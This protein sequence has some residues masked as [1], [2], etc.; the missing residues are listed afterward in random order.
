M[1]RAAPTL[2]LDTCAMI[3]I[4]NASRIDDVADR[5]IGK[6]AADNRLFISPMSA[7][8]MGIGVA[9]GRLM[10]P[11]GPLEFF[12]RFVAQIGARPSPLTPEILVGSSMLPGSPHNDPMDRIL[13]ATARM[14]DMILV[15]RDRPILTYSEAG[16]V[17]T[18]VC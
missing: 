4:G 6:A 14:L 15:T 2:L 13:M 18:L 5:A 12:N 17:R 9:K 1:S 3:F 8:E 10:L 16:H 7:W 11:L